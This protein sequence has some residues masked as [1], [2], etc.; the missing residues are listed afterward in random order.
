MLSSIISY[1]NCL[2]NIEPKFY[3]LGTLGH[4]QWSKMTVSAIDSGGPVVCQS[5]YLMICT[6][7]YCRSM[8]RGFRNLM[9]CLHANCLILLHCWFGGTPIKWS[10]SLS[11]GGFRLIFSFTPWCIT[12]DDSQTLFVFIFMRRYIW[13]CGTKFVVKVWQL[14]NANVWS[15][16]NSTLISEF[17]RKYIQ[18]YAP[19][20]F[21]VWTLV[22][23]GVG[24][25]HIS[26]PPPVCDGRGKDATANCQ[27]MRLKRPNKLSTKLS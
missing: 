17:W 23:G 9:A 7:C 26:L 16:N 4:F 6:I 19:T 3:A 27:P 18:I 2:L 25:H 21:L 13:W 8:H 15:P 11:V 20:R 12:R 24:T 14:A 1:N 5:W 22:N 10:K